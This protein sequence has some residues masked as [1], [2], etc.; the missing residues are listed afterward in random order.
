MHPTVKIILL[1]GN[2]GRKAIY[3]DAHTVSKHVCKDDAQSLAWYDILQVCKEQIILLVTQR[4]LA[5]DN[6][7][8][9]K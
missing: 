6:N 9:Q 4:A 5:K 8:F 3:D 7:V 2:F 1:V